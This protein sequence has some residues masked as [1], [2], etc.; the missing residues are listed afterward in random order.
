MEL[1]YGFDL[2]DAESAVALLK[3]DTPGEAPVLTVQGAKSFV[4]AFA[5]LDTGELMIGEEACFT[6]GAGVRKVRFK[7]RFLTDP[8][9]AKDVR[10]F[11]SG[12]LGRLRSSGDLIDGS[13][14]CFYVAT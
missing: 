1:F 9:A 4:T 3:K 5:V 6:P 8:A 12:V 13:D 7:T 2:G 10:S 14:S 11:A